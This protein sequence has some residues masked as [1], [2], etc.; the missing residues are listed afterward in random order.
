M[1]SS[2]RNSVTEN[3]YEPAIEFHAYSIRMSAPV[4][5]SPLGVN[6]FNQSTTLPLVLVALARVYLLL[7]VRAGPVLAAVSHKGPQTDLWR[8]T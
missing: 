1:L 3:G 7:Q 4:V 5:P 6:T 8:G 2:Y